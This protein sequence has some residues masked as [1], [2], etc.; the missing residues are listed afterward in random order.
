MKA[1]MI[2]MPDVK[3][4]CGF[5]SLEMHTWT[6]RTDHLGDHFKAGATMADW[7]GDWGFTEE[8]EQL[9][10][11]SVPPCKSIIHADDD[12]TQY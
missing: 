3:S 5:C 4:R 6:E 10:E 11:H 12:L 1:W 9:V 8:T 2:A 7:K